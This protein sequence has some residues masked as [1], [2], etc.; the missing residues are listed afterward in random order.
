MP[1]PPQWR[2][3][4]QQDRSGSEFSPQMLCDLKQSPYLLGASVFISEPWKGLVPWFLTLHTECS[5]FLA[6]AL[7]PFTW[8]WNSYMR[9]ERPSPPVAKCMDPGPRHAGF[10]LHFCCSPAVPWASP[11]PCLCLSLL[12]CHLGVSIALTPEGGVGIKQITHG[13]AQNSKPRT[14]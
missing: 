12:S 14:E 8:T 13:R 5:L 2:E 7:L 4:E 3:L 6:N 11:S 10:K 1:L 9:G